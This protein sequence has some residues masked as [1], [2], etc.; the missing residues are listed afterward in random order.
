MTVRLQCE[1]GVSMAHAKTTN[2]SRPTR[3]LHVCSR[4]CAMWTMREACILPFQSLPSILW[5]A[6]IFFGWQWWWYGT[7]THLLHDFSYFLSL[8]SLFF[9]LSL[10][11]VFLCGIWII[12]FSSMHCWA[13]KYQH[14]L[15]FLCVKWE[16]AIWL[17]HLFICIWKLFSLK[18]V[19]PQNQPV[20]HTL[21]H[22]IL[23]V[24]MCVR[25]RVYVYL[26]FFQIRSIGN[27]RTFF[28]HV[29]IFYLN[30]FHLKYFKNVKQ[31]Q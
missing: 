15:I 14:L 19:F 4:F 12:D 20:I 23:Y 24:Y 2:H 30:V 22:L 13:R 10:S 25:A 27:A 11:L 31:I 17:K 9:S 8:F 18:L 28:F 21:P 26:C 29:D 5:W 6:C 1:R 7:L 3:C 16:T